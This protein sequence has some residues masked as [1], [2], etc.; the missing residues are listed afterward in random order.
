MTTA[1]I[2]IA[3]GT[4]VIG[5]RVVPELVRAGFG[6]TAAARSAAGRAALQGL[7]ATAVELNLF[8]RGSVANAVRDQDVVI[9]MATHVPSSRRALLPWSWREN[10]RVR[11]LV[12]ANFAAA[13]L[14]GRATRLIQ[15]SFAPV[16]EP[17]GDRWID[18][19]SPVRPASYNRTVLDAESAADR[20]SAGGKV[21]IALRFAYFYGSDSDFSQD[22]V[23]MV[24][25]GRAP[26]L[27]DPDGYCSSVEHDDAAHAVVAA[28]ALPAGIYNVTDDE[29]VTRRVFADAMAL[30]LGLAPPR[31]FPAWVGKAMGSV[32]ETLSRSQ[33]ISNRKL[34][35]SSGWAPRYPSVREG[36]A[37]V[38]RRL[39]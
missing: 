39:L 19:Q 33:R 32:A 28:L 14:A 26:L 7:G 36:W 2:F 21:G 31:F 38:L 11:R 3:G 24:R 16:Y 10:S 25:R 27:G 13:V 29:P 8:D 35:A 17:A 1:S 15:E 34:R 23:A 22:G 5:R 6:V 9:N 30:A 37:A 4:G 18:E 12:S 20:V